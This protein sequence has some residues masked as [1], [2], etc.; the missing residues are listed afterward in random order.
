MVCALCLGLL[1]VS[2][3]ADDASVLNIAIDGEPESLDIAMGSM[4]LASEVVYGSVFE[5]LVAFDGQN[6][7][8]PELAESWEMSEDATTYTYVL[9]QGIKFHN[10][11]EMKAADVVASMNRWLDNASNA[12]ELVGDARFEAVDDYTVQI[13]M[14]QGTLYLN[15]MIC[16][17]GQHAVIMPASVIDSVGE[18]ELVREYVGTGPYKF[19]E[20][21]ADRYIKL[22][23]SDD[24]VPYGTEGDYS[25][26]AGYKTAWYDEVYFYFPGDEA[27]VY[28]GI[29]TG[30]YDM[31]AG[32]SG[33]YYTLLADD[34][35]FTVF[36]DESEMPML[37]FNKGV[38]VGSNALIR[39]A[40]QAAVNCDDV[41]LA[42]MAD[43]A[44][45]KTYS[46]YMFES[47][48]NWYSEAGGENYNQNDPDKALALFE[49]AGWDFDNDVFRILVNSGASDFTTQAYVIQEELRGIGVTCD[50]LAYDSATYSDTRNNKTEEWDAFIT[51]FSPKVLPNMN[52]FLS[53]GWPAEGTGCVDE[54]VQGDLAAIAAETDLD[55]A[56]ALW[57]DLQEYMYTEYVPVVKFG[58]TVLWGVS[59]S[60]I[61]GAFAKERLTW[62]DAR[63][64]A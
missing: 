52:L 42:S 41:L 7:I 21:P 10:G 13:V 20:W 37:I 16:G 27:T 39:Q 11:E 35:D 34:P 30:E 40:V 23:R 19:E 60:S 53:T 1:A 18:G 58:T 54:R 12:G 61:T 64:A 63:P 46:S 14:E 6:Q 49:E 44:F 24:Y 38:G 17:L 50:V 33:D 4:D 25:G 36:T 31:T 22:V 5:Q 48:A 62:I 56:V 32:L 55:A 59:T 9:R 29:K 51:S 26:W 43:E 15:E 57:N 47:S 45:Y 8:T 3:G 28:N 2:V